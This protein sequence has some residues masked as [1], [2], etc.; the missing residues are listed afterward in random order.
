MLFTISLSAQQETV[1]TG[2]LLGH[3]KKPMPM[4]HVY[5]IKSPKPQP[6]ANVQAGSDG[7]FKLS[8]VETGMLVLEFSGVNH[9]AFDVPVLLE[10]PTTFDVTVTLASVLLRRQDG[11]HQDYD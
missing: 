7:T 2:K 3:D 4:A 10:K 8:T 6:V 11:Q 9:S 1:I 5:L